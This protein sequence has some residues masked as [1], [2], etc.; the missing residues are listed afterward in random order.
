MFT[1]GMVPSSRLSPQREV[2]ELY[3]TWNVQQSPVASSQTGS[4][5]FV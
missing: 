1:S 5:L 3:G 4:L 2:S